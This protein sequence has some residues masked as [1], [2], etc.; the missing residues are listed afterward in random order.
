M[1][2]VATALL[3]DRNGQLLIYLRD[4]KPE[5]SFPGYWDLFGG[6]VEP[7]ETPEQALVR[8]VEEELGI[9]IDNYTLYKTYE[10]HTEARPNVKYVYVVHIPQAAGELTLYEG[11]YHIGINLA[12]RRNYAFANILGNILD[13][14]GASVV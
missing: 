14:Y 6:R 2:Q 4:N 12:D 9:K 5:I 13:D 10:S 1:H 11:Q 3:F 7:G 8:E